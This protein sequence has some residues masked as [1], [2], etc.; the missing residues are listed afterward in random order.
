MRINNYKHYNRS[1]NF[2][3]V[4]KEFLKLAKEEHAIMNTVSGDLIEKLQYKILTKKILPQDGLDTIDAI[5]P[6]T[7]KKYQN[8]FEPLIEFCKFLQN[9]KTTK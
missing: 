6:Y 2:T 5:I 7:K 1:N 4:N 9:K 8:L 3:A